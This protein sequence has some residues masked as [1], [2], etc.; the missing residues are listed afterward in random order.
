MAFSLTGM[1]SAQTE[2]NNNLTVEQKAEKLTEKMKKS[3]NL[4]EAQVP[5]VKEANIKMIQERE[6]LKLE[7]QRRKKELHD[8][9]R[10]QL[11]GILTPEQMKK[12]DDKMKK[13]EK[14][15]KRKHEKE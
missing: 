7:T 9:H 14:K 2:K 4:T 5:R 3:L 8:N 13:R 6:N 12:A 1:V 10:N 11:A 15:M